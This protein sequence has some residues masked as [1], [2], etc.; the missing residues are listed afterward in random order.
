[1]LFEAQGTARNQKHRARGYS[2]SDRSPERGGNREKRR[3][4]RTLSLKWGKDRKW[5]GKFPRAFLWT[6]GSITVW[7]GDG[8]GTNSGPIDR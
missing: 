5:Q 7:G 8:G 6:P 4:S 1:V 2:P 3:K